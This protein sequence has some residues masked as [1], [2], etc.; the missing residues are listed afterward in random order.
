MLLRVLTDYMDEPEDKEDKSKKVKRNY[1]FGFVKKEK[2]KGL[3]PEI[4]ENILNERKKV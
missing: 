2:C 3:L 1:E 4:L